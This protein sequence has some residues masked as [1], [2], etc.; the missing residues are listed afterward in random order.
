MVYRPG[1]TVLTVNWNSLEFL[2]VMLD[3]TR[4]MS[5]QDTEV[6]VV[7]NG[8]SDG[9]L[10]FLRSHQDVRVLRLPFNV[11]HGPALDIAVPLVDTEFLAVLDID[12][13]PV[14][15]DWLSASVSAL[16]GGAK[17][18]GA[19]AYRNYIHPCFLV[20]HTPMLHEYDL[21][22]RSFRRARHRFRKAPLMLDVGESL[23]QRVIL[24]FGG[25]HALHRFPM[26]SVE[27]P[28]TAGATFGG[29]VY[30]HQGATWWSR[31]AE[32]PE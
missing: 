9:S 6:F 5:P 21:T 15:P 26:T 7:D 11:G 30:H 1:V 16:R 27:G 19:H 23:S 31:Q 18:A 24:H 20:T 25:G 17:I 2:R 4:A 29:L 8:S 13:F 22:F 12:A 14:S 10:E 3:A 28:G 32:E